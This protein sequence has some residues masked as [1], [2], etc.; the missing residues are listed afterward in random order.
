MGVKG[1]FVCLLKRNTTKDYSKSTHI[2]NMCGAGKKLRKPKIKKPLEE[3][4][5]KDPRNHFRLKKE[6]EATRGRITRDIKSLSK[7]EEV[8]EILLH[9][10]KGW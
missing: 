10:S 7:L 1:K 5:F 8:K 6:N 4:I 3:N 2:S 9:V